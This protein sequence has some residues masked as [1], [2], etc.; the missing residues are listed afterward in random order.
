MGACPAGALQIR[1]GC[2]E[3]EIWIDEGAVW[4]AVFHPRGQIHRP[5][6]GKSM[7]NVRNQKKLYLVEHQVFGDRSGRG[8]MEEAEEVSRAHI[9][10][11]LISHCQK[12]GLQLGGNVNLL[13]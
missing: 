8:G 3:A 12:P 2:L 13:K 6:V 5:S 9:T 4:R 10:K 11:G 7:A 1:E